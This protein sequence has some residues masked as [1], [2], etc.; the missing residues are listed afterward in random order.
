MQHCGQD[1]QERIRDQFH[2]AEGKQAFIEL[3]VLHLVANNIVYQ[4]SQR[5]FTRLVETARGSLHRIGEHY[6]SG[7]PSL[8]LRA[9]I[10]EPFFQSGRGFVGATAICHC[11]VIEVSDQRC[12]MMFADDIAYLFRQPVLLRNLQAVSNVRGYDQSG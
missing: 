11:L 12:S 3:P 5:L 8:G 1:M 9:R 2:L 10:P 7:L 4:P 6:D